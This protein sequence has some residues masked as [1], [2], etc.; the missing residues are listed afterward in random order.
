MNIKVGDKVRIKTEDELLAEGWQKKL[1]FIGETSHYV[2]GNFI[3]WKDQCG[4]VEKV[5]R[6]LERY[7]ETEKSGNIPIEAI[8]EII[9]QTLYEYICSLPLEEMA[10]W[11]VESLKETE[12]RPALYHSMFAMVPPFF[13]TYDEALQVTIKALNQ[14]KEN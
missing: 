10:K 4:N 2:K 6:V 14:T 1:N 3:L 9:P 8:A 7:V 5:I 13:T 11:F 12:E